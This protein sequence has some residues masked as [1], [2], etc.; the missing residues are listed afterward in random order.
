M[1]EAG[2]GGA[3]GGAA[4]P[5]CWFCS[6]GRHSECMREI[7]VHGGSDGPHDC[8][9]DTAVVA[10]GCCGGGGGGG[11]PAAGAAGR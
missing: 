6:R 10:C 8:S 3:A 4:G 5:A 9:F 7:P 2:A 11:G 1:A